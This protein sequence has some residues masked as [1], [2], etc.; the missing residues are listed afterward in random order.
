MPKN[1]VIF[2]GDAKPESVVTISNGDNQIVAKTKT[3]SDG[4]YS[5][6][7]ANV[8]S[9]N[10]VF[11]LTNEAEQKTFIV[12]MYSDS[13]VKYNDVS[14]KNLTWLKIMS[15]ITAYEKRWNLDLTER[16]TKIN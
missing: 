1:S 4:K 11:T 14:L 6:S 5:I 7:V 9:A 13:V 3:D 16:Q 2:E 8:S 12:N 15:L 10:N